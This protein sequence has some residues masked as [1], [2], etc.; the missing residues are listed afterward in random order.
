M[1]TPL[2]KIITTSVFCAAIFFATP[3]IKAN[4]QAAD[5]NELFTL[6]ERTAYSNRYKNLNIKLKPEAGTVLVPTN[7]GKSLSVDCAYVYDRD[8]GGNPMLVPRI[9]ALDRGD[10]L[11]LKLQN[12]LGNTTYGKTNM[13]THGF[14]VLAKKEKW[15]GSGYDGEW[16]DYV[17]FTVP[18]AKSVKSDCDV[19]SR[20]QPTN[21]TMSHG[22]VSGTP[23]GETFVDERVVVPYEIPVSNDHPAGLFWYHPHP[24]GITRRQVAGGMAGLITVGSIG[25]YACIQKPD[26][27]VGCPKSDDIWKFRTN[28]PRNIKYLILKDIVTWREKPEIPGLTGGEI[29][30]FYPGADLPKGCPTANEDNISPTSA[31]GY[32]EST[33][34]ASNEPEKDKIFDWLFTVNGQLQPHIST[35]L[36]NGKRLSDDLIKLGDVWRVANMSADVTYDLEIRCKGTET[37]IPFAVIGRDGVS[38]GGDEQSTNHLVIMPAG[39]ADIHVSPADVPTTCRTADVVEAELYTKG[40]N[41]GGDTWPVMK[42]ADISFANTVMPASRMLMAAPAADR[43]NTPPLAEI[44]AS[45]SFRETGRSTEQCTAVDAGKD[46]I[47]IVWFGNRID[48]NYKNG[49]NFDGRLSG[50]EIT[51]SPQKADGSKNAQMITN[52]DDDVIDKLLPDSREFIDADGIPEPFM[53]ANEVGDAVFESDDNNSKFQH[54]LTSYVRTASG[55]DGQDVRLRLFPHDLGIV[56]NAPDI[57]LNVGHKERWLLVNTTTEIHNFHIHQS[58]FAVLRIYDPENTARLCDNGNDPCDK[59]YNVNGEVHDTIP[60]PPRGYTLI[61]IGFGNTPTD[62][63]KPTPVDGL[64]DANGTSLQVGDFVFHC[65]ILEHED[66]GMMGLIRVLPEAKT[67]AVN[68]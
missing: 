10:T 37:T 39:R 27:K 25:D 18:P 35:G 33:D 22:T 7:M 8:F 6:A 26:D 9:W 53:L 59:D 50:A 30:R 61:E 55:L 58:K 51:L 56:R 42:L 2:L 57:C 1:K 32:C 68:K 67:A 43:T 31:F 63:S 47:R 4:A 15:S 62:G 65:H 46:Q 19:S 52:L 24:H 3:H 60:V 20:V 28:G 5:S 38:V 29:L 12:K 40:F 48:K 21:H 14:L 17:L 11:K 23:S 66:G 36:V 44:M 64:T 34:K 16:G 41:T 45:K 13:H 54:K 49:G